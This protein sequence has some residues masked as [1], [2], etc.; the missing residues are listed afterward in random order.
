VLG[1]IDILRLLAD[2]TVTVDVRNRE[3]LTPLL[4][5][6]E[7]RHVRTVD[8]LLGK[9]ADVKAVDT[10]GKTALHWAVIGGHPGVVYALLAAGVDPRARDR[11]GLT[12]L[13][14]ARKRGRILLAEI[15]ETGKAF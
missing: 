3:G 2:R 4:L 1:R 7:N 5:A 14:L 9:G 11:V 13:A 12:A 10:S 6:C 15:L 8:L